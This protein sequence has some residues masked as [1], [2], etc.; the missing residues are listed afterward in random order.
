MRI[1]ASSAFVIMLSAALPFWYTGGV[2]T[3]WSWS[4]KIS[5]L[6]APPMPSDPPMHRE[7]AA[8]Q[9]VMLGRGTRRGAPRF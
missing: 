1:L 3:E 8:T 5:L 4:L 6:L 7:A 9:Q 2:Q